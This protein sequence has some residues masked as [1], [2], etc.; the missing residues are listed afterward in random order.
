ML[1][2]TVCFI[3]ITPDG[4]SRF[5]YAAEDVTERRRSQN[6]LHGKARQYRDLY[7][8]AQRRE[9]ELA[10]QDKVRTALMHELDPSSVIRTVVQGI[11]GTLGYTHVSIY[12]L[13]GKTLEFNIRLVMR[14]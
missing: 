8:A 13:K 6:V 11:A 12:L 1:L 10:L 9:Q 2:V 3:N 5:S 14:T 4:W 7:A